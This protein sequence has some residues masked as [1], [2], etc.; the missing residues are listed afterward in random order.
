[1]GAQEDGQE[2]RGRLG[3]AGVSGL[4][5]E[6]RQTADPCRRQERLRG[7][8]A[9][10]VV[11]SSF[12]GPRNEQGSALARK[13]GLVACNGSRRMQQQQTRTQ[14]CGA[15]RVVPLARPVIIPLHPT[16]RPAVDRTDLATQLSTAH[17][18]RAAQLA[19]SIHSPQH[20][21]CSIRR[22]SPRA[23]ESP[24]NYHH[25]QLSDRERVG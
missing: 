3:R 24:F 16:L 22:C 13:P 20:S 14:T 12:R 23:R 6:V 25:I 18:R 10:Q 4:F 21:L 7:H 8:D 19:P 9:G 15:C 1:M 5:P 17:P 2:Q 11:M